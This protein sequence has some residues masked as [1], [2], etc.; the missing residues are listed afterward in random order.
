[1]LRQY[2]NYNER[3][4][5]FLPCFC[6]ILCYVGW[7]FIRQFSFANFSIV[8]CIVIMYLT[9]STYFLVRFLLVFWEVLKFWSNQTFALEFTYQKSLTFEILTILTMEIFSFWFIN[10][11][12]VFICHYLQFDI[13]ILLIQ[14]LMHWRLFKIDEKAMCKFF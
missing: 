11:V 6:N 3:L 2:F 1:M 14:L 7:L 5:I 8:F 13:I 12:N 4:E 9:S 10:A